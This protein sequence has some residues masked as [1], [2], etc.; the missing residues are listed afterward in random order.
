MNKN[1]KERF[2][3]YSV[4]IERLTFTIDLTAHLVSNV[5]CGDKADDVDYVNRT[6]ALMDS[7]VELAHKRNDECEELL[8]LFYEG[9]EQ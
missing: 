5:I 1:F 4:A 6:E 3:Q 9:E 2:E 7:L 8:R